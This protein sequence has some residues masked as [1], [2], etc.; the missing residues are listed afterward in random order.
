[1]DITVD[2]MRVLA[3]YIIWILELMSSAVFVVQLTQCLG[4][5]ATLLLEPL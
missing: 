1:V 5:T 2:A 4:D 3:P